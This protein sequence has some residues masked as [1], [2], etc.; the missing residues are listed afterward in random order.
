MHACHLNSSLPTIFG[1]LFKPFNEQIS[2]NSRGASRYILNILTKMKTVKWGYLDQRG[3]F[4]HFITEIA[5]RTK[6]IKL[7]HLY[8]Y[9]EPTDHI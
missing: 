9:D 5:Q 1:D 2:Y 4:D 7:N 6:V 8:P 3:Y